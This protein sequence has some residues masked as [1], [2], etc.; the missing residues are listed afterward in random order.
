MENH[1]PEAQA[2][3]SLP[4]M[5]IQ[6]QKAREEGRMVNQEDSQLVP[7]DQRAPISRWGEQVAERFGQQADRQIFLF[8][9]GRKLEDLPEP[10]K[11]LD[12]ESSSASQVSFEE[13]GLEAG[14]EFLYIAQNRRRST[15]RCRVG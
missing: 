7:A 9:Y 4:G 3:S 14:E 11:E 2:R 6:V 1:Q 12:G 13:L 15:Y 8:S 5:E 10:A